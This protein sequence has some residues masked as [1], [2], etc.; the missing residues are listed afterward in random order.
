MKNCSNTFKIFVFILLS[1]L[2]NSCGSGKEGD[3]FE[4]A[5]FNAY[6]KS[7]N[8]RVEAYFDANQPQAGN[9]PI[10]SPKVYIDF[11]NGLIQAYQG[12]PDNAAMLEK[13]TQ[14]LTGPDIK[15]YGMGR[16]QINK[17]DF[18]TTELFNK[19]TD[20]QSY[21][22][23]MMAPIE[24]AVKQIT[25][26]KSDALLVTDF[27]EYTTDGREQFE[28]FARDYF[29]D[30]LSKGNSIDFYVTNYQEKTR[31][32]RTV[33]K[34]L[35][36]I[37]FNYGTEKK[38]L[39]DINY[40]LKDRGYKYETFSLSTDFYSLTNDYGSEKK[41]GIYY[42]EKGEDIILLSDVNQYINGINKSKK[43]FEFYSFQ[44]S[45]KDIYANSKSM[46]GPGVPLPFT[47]FFRKLYLD[48]SKDDV[49]QLKGLEVKV[50][51]VTDDFLFHA[52]TKEVCLHKPLLTK[53]ADGN[54]I[55][56]PNET[57][58]IALSCYDNK[59][60]L[61]GSWVY[62]P[63]GKTGLNEMFVLNTDLYNNGFKDT[64]NKI[65]IGT[66]YHNNFNGTL[67][68]P[69]ALL[70]VDIVVADCNPNF[71]NLGLFKWESST[72][73][74]RSNESLSEAIRNTL[75]RVNPKGKVIYTYFIQ[76]IAN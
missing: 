26:S 65:E 40:A 42:D 71:A 1:W 54:S 21:A 52:K 67:P 63:K 60:N 61:Q 70:R 56:S 13:I 17:L 76:S 18:V 32:R 29:I 47:D 53:D 69:L 28:N 55:F 35:Y 64:K 58:P 48:A 30:W 62:A 14:K 20:P 10:D 6:D 3:P 8:T 24:V 59:G 39:G 36:F 4:Q 41:G 27:E 19:V 46:M 22:S 16:G 57:N 37:V 50:S 72:V 75:D 5:G 31:D 2:L 49:F 73:R 68:N 23:Q 33:D 7:L 51:D 38:L 43:M 25:S 9:L 74:G 45:W 15:W 66:K 11:S 44:L 12:N 34:H